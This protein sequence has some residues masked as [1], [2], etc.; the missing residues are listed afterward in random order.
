[1]NLSLNQFESATATATG[2]AEFVLSLQGGEASVPAPQPVQFGACLPPGL[3]T[4]SVSARLMWGEDASVAVQTEPLMRHPDGSIQWLLADAVLPAGCAVG[5]EVRLVIDDED[6]HTDK[7]KSASTDKDQFVVRCGSRQLRLRLSAGRFLLEELDG[8]ACFFRDAG[9]EFTFENRRSQRIEPTWESLFQETCG[10]IRNTFLLEATIGRRK[11]SRLNLS[12]RLSFYAGTGLIKVD[13]CL[14]NPRRARHKG[15][16]W[17]LGDPGSELFEDFSVLIRHRFGREGLLS[18][19]L[20]DDTPLETS[21]GTKLR[22]YQDSSGGENWNSANHVNRDG[23]VPCQFRGYR[24]EVGGD[25]RE[26][27]RATPVIALGNAENALSVAFPEFWQQFPKCLEPDESVIRVGLFPTE[28]DDLHELQ[29]GERKT[30]TFWLHLAAGP[31]AVERSLH[32]ARAVLDPVLITPSRDAFAKHGVIQDGTDVL[33]GDSRNLDRLIERALDG[34]RS[35]FVKRETIDEFGWRNYG[36]IVADH[37]ERYYDGP[38]PLVSH[39]NNQFDTIYGLLLNYLRTGD[40]R[41]FELGDALARHVVDI[42]VYHT[43]EDKW[44]YNGGQFWHTDHYLHAKSSTHRGFS[45]ENAPE[46]GDYGGGPCNEHNYTTG[47]LLHY[48]LTG[49]GRSRDTVLGLAD[50]V[51]QMDDGR[52]SLFRY[53]AQGPTGLASMTREETFHGPGRGSG[54][55]VNALLDAWRLSNERRYLQFSEELIRRCIHPADDLE[56]L[57]LLNAEDRWSYT[58]FLTSLMKYLKTKSEMKEFDAA[59]S[60]ARA[61]LVHY[62]VWMAEH[63][64]TILD[65]S[66]KL[67]FPTETWAAQDLRKANVMRHAAAYLDEPQKSRVFAAGAAI[68]ERSWEDLWSFDT[69]ACARPFSILMVEG[70]K[71]VT[72]SATVN[73]ESYGFV[74]GNGFGEPVRFV[75]QKT[76]IKRLLKSP[77]RLVKGFLSK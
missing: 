62:A 15:G 43:S 42:D 67:E 18:W 31:N 3:A 65:A 13:V 64:R 66:D 49:N 40:R 72:A 69:A 16:L 74:A 30:T 19:S 59:Y 53:V 21:A 47:L 7:S 28:W 8:D 22:L 10:S 34:D 45:S 71:E 12:C 2:A 29:G 1:M 57:D 76:R 35:I 37:E 26:G 52:R 11:R 77:Q 54:N 20:G 24:L 75:G 27:L 33:I 68:A 23:R 36:E 14:H 6:R 41:L 58:V 51:I 70:L 50:W 44:G 60:Y 25:R 56:Q 61:A 55:S 39:Y 38:L 9:I 63:E 48:C 46:S 4:D 17:D 73:D 5:D 32:E